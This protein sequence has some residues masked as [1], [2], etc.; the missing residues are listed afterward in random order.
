MQQF[1]AGLGV[2]T[3]EVQSRCRRKLQALA[4]EVPSTPP[5]TPPHAPYVV[6]IG[7]SV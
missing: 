6:P 1:F 2:R 4:E 5:E 3:A 7:A